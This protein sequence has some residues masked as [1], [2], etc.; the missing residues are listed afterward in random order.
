[1]RRWGEQMHWRV[2][3]H[4]GARS[5]ASWQVWARHVSGS[6]L[7]SCVDGV[8]QQVRGSEGKLRD[9]VVHGGWERRE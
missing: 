1:M 6:G 4:A 2:Q 3:G 9:M 8:Y 5:G 7:L